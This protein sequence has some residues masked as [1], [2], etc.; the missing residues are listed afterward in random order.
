MPEKGSEEKFVRVAVNRPLRQA[1]D[2][3]IPE[4]V[5]APA[6]GTLLKVPFGHTTAVAICV[7]LARGSDTGAEIKPVLEVLGDRPALTPELM[8]LLRWAA[9]YYHHPLGEVL[10]AALPP[11]RKQGRRVRE[12]KADDAG[13]DWQPEEAHAANPEQAQAL[14]AVAQARD[15]QVFLLMG[16]TGSGKT[17]VYL[18]AIEKVLAR[19]QQA[20]VLVPEIGLTPQ[21]V[22]RFERRFERVAVSHSELTA[23][24]RDAARMRCQSGHAQVLI[25]TRS[26]VFTPFSNLGLIVVDEEHDSSYKQMTGFAYSAR[27]FAVKRAQLLGIPLVLGS[28]TPS[29]ESMANADQGRYTLLRLSQ[30]TAGA[31]LPTIRLADIRGERLAK[32]RAGIGSELLRRMQAHLAQGQQVLLFLNR[33]GFAPVLQC[34]DC[35]WKAECSACEWPLTLH[36]TPACLRCHHCGLEARPISACPECGASE[37]LPFGAGTQRVAELVGERFPGVP[38]IRIDRD[39]VRGN[40]IASRLAEIPAGEP[41][42]LVGTQMLAKGHHF[43]DITLVGVL[44]ADFGFVSPDFR[45]PEHTAQLILQVAG[46]AGR[47]ERPGE[48]LIQ[49]LHP[50]HSALKLLAGKGYEVFARQLLK[51]REAAGLPPFGR[52]ALL[53]ADSPKAE[54]ARQWLEKLAKIARHAQAADVLGPLPAPAPKRANRYRFACVLLARTRAQL[55]ATLSCLEANLPKRKPGGVRWMIDVDPFESL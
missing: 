19:G 28:A 42:I 49:T 14:A 53:R 7:E 20:M 24:M 25:G 27:D 33:R 46:R 36:Q 13:A 21:S 11:G 6:P 54:N 4:N 47:A 38:V 32:E 34:A 8:K 44:G 55:H 12:P 15:F 1:F 39:T 43:P 45:A 10:F 41:A 51:E 50:E 22:A 5:E 17:E 48:V 35:G 26:A 30:R 18:Q 23:G 2:Y 37:L 31:R 52:L 3:E 40:R 16:I 29:L 9:D